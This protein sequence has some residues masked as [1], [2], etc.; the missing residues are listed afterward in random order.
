[1][2]QAGGGDLSKAVVL[3]SGGL[4][5][6]TTLAYALSKGYE[7]VALTIGYGQRHS[8]ELRSARAVAE[9]YRLTKHVEM[10]LD[11]SFLTTSALTSWTVDV[12]QRKSVDGIDAEIP[13][14]YVPGRNIILLS[15]AASLCEN[16]GGE[17]VFIGANAVDYS[18]YPDCRPQFIKAFQRVLDV[19]TRMGVE[20]N[21]IK[22]EA[23]IIRMSKA[24]IVKLATELKAPLHLTWSCYQG[25]ERACGRCDSCLLRLKGFKDAGLTDPVPYEAR[26]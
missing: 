9:H 25:G 2:G 15:L 6:T 14:T 3:L 4:D 23:P 24:E 10:E 17:A 5:S 12:P 19:G 1:M 21:P 7:V 13:A 26:P 16:E 11:L 20:G 18:G 22:I 8:R